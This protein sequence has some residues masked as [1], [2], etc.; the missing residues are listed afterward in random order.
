MYCN[1][2]GETI[3]EAADHSDA[4]MDDNLVTDELSSILPCP[5]L[6]PDN[7]DCCGSGCVP[8]VFDIY[9]QDLKIWKQECR[10]IQEHQRGPESQVMN[11]IYYMS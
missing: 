8:C 3:S 4:V 9:E 11:L 10:R 2:T 5:P 7:G 6:Q 1:D